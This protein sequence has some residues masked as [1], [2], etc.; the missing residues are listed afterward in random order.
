[1]IEDIERVCRG[2]KI[3]NEMAVQF[4]STGGSGMVTPEKEISDWL[5]QVKSAITA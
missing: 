5:E 1:M 4:D 3:V 2:A